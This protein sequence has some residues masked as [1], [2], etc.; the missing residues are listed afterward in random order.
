[1]LAFLKRFQIPV[2]I[3]I[4]AAC[5]TGTSV[6]AQNTAAGGGGYQIAVVDMQKL[7]AEYPKRKAKYEALQ[8]EVDAQQKGIDDML[9]SIQTQEENLKSSAANMTDDQRRAAIDKIEQDRSAWRM[10][11][12]RR[13]RNVDRQE[14]DVLREVLQD[15]EGAVSQIAMSQNFHLILNKGGSSRSVVWFSPTI[16]ITSSVE[17]VLNR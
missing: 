3:A 10:E 17:A 5:V 4:I 15:I 9:K 2:A 7:I 11:V 13:Q 6:L 14:E 8:R 12:E 16:D 1:M